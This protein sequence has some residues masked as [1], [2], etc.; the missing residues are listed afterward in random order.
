MDD[1]IKE[2]RLIHDFTPYFNTTVVNTPPR[3]HKK[4]KADDE[5]GY[6][7]TPKSNISILTSDQEKELFTRITDL[8]RD[9]LVNLLLNLLEKHPEEKFEVL[10]AISTSTEDT[11]DHFP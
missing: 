10:Y 4:R 11:T 9:H 6:D 8:N 7:S 3:K 2:G 5:N 1:S